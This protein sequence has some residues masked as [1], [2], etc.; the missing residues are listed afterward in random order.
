MILCVFCFF[1]TSVAFIVVVFN[2]RESVAYVPFRAASYTGILE[3]RGQN[4]G[5]LFK[6]SFTDI[7]ERDKE[8]A[9]IYLRKKFTGKNV[10]FTLHRVQKGENFWGIAKKYGVTID[11][12]IGANPD[13]KDLLARIGQDILVLSEKGVL[14]EVRDRDEDLNL[15]EKLYGIKK[16]RI[17]K[18]NNLSGGRIE[19]GDVL[20]IPGAKP[21]YM[22]ESL[23]ELFNKRKMFRSP[24]SGV[25]T[26]LFGSR[27]HPVTGLRDFHKGVDIRAKIGSWVGASSS[28]KVVYAG[29]LGNMGYC[30]KIRHKSGYVS[31][32]GHLSKLYV[33]PG[34]HVDAGKLIAKTGN[35]G[36][37]TGP[38][39]HFG[40][41]KNGRAKDPMKYLW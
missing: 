34:Q 16:N 26:S 40:I 33:R 12:I 13:L 17:N 29:W 39:L 9:Y 36:R 38:H 27:T 5:E 18:F 6:D 21:V 8:L 3:S 11:T 37:T 31:L 28:G 10:N 19:I 1:I 15:L 35:S 32:Y 22:S 20:F 2:A 7:A 41:Y 23:K 25:Y 4:L 14:H 30:V 24:L